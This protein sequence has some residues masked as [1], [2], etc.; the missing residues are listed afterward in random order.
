MNEHE[1]EAATSLEIVLETDTW[2]RNKA[3]MK[4]ENPEKQDSN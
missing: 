4:L 2:A 3:I 1:S